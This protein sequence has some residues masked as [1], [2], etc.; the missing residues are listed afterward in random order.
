MLFRYALEMAICVCSG[1]LLT[2]VGLVELTGRA[3]Q[4]SEVPILRAAYD[5]QMQVAWF[6][7]PRLELVSAHEPGS[8]LQPSSPD[9][10][11]GVSWVAFF[12]L[13][14]FVLWMRSDALLHTTVLRVW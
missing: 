5:H 3:E 4:S 12:A 10:R 2:D 8:S 13:V 9:S 1:A 6:V 7:P 14:V 11:L